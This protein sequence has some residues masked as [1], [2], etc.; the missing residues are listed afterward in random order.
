VPYLAAPARALDLT[1][2]PPALVYVGTLDGFCDED[3]LY[4]MRLYQAGV[5]TQLHVYPGAPHGFDGFAPGAQIS[6]LSQYNSLEWLRTALAGPH[7]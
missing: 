2:L 6:R 1:G 7:F 5:P 4:A 3:V